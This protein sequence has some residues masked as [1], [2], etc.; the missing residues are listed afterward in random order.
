MHDPVTVEVAPRYR[1]VELVSQADYPVDRER[2]R[3]L[4]A[5]LVNRLVQ[6]LERAAIEADAIHG[7]K[8][9]GAR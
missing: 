7:N 3:D 2:K 8:S 1:P 9:Q 4:L 5:H 6:Q